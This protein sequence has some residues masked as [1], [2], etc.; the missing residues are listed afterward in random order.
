MWKETIYKVVLEIE[1]IGA[2]MCRFVQRF[3]IF[4]IILMFAFFSYIYIDNL[5]S[6]NNGLYP[7]PRISHRRTNTLPTIAIYVKLYYLGVGLILLYNLVYNYV[8]A[9]RVGPGHPF[10]IH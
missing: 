6:S 2:I 7:D 9:Y 4:A 10:N 3:L 8:M 1:R 5:F